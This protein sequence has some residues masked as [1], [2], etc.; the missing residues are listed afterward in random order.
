MGAK[1]E[2]CTVM[3]FLHLLPWWISIKPPKVRIGVHT[4][5]RIAQVMSFTCNRLRLRTAADNR[6]QLPDHKE[7]HRRVATGRIKPERYHM[8]PNWKLTQVMLL[9]A[10][11]SVVL[12]AAQPG[13]KISDPL[14]IT[15][16]PATMGQNVQAMFTVVN[17][18]DSVITLGYVVAAA[19]EDATG[20]NIDFP[21][22]QNPD[23]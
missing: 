22:V 7:A 3:E 13:V 15:P 8:K 9:A 14:R 19:R 17:S 21:G 11:S 4:A 6:R 18:G 23:A 10:L 20:A 16:N 5:Q 1:F 12:F 2:G